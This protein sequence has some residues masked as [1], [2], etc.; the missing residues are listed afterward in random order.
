MST[1]TGVK[2]LT[3]TF[4]TFFRFPASNEK[5][6]FKQM[7]RFLRFLTH[8]A[9]LKVE[10][11]QSPCT[12]GKTIWLGKIDASDPD[13]EIL[14]LGHGIHEVMHVVHTDM[15]CVNRYGDTTIGRLLLNVLEDVR[16]DIL[17]TTHFAG[18]KAWRSRLVEVLE[19]R[20]SLSMNVE[21]RTLQPAELLGF[22]LHT[23][24]MV[25]AGFDW[26][27]KYIEKLE[28]DIEDKIDTK[29][30]KRIIQLAM[31]TFEAV[32][33]TDVTVLVDQMLKILRAENQGLQMQNQQ[34]SLFDDNPFVD[35]MGVDSTATTAANFMHAVVTAKTAHQ[36]GELVAPKDALQNDGKPCK[37]D[38]ADAYW[39]DESTNPIVVADARD[40]ARAFESVVDDVAAMSR[41]FEELLETEDF[42][43]IEHATNGNCFCDNLLD[44]TARKDPRIFIRQA[45]ER[46]VDAEICIL[47]D[48]SGSMGVHTMTQAKAAVLGMIEAL[49]KVEG[50]RVRAACFPGPVKSHVS[51]IA[52][53]EE[54][55]ETIADRITKIGAYGATP[56]EEALLWGKESFC[57]TEDARDRL[58]LVITD[59]RFPSSYSQRLEE[60]L[61]D[62]GVELAILS[63]DIANTDACTNCCHIEDIEELQPALLNLFSRTRFCE[64]MQPE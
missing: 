9:D 53:P 49:R 37:L 23:K 16:I 38:E 34:L 42:T 57:K 32:N 4:P 21:N 6:R 27:D 1:S 47:L 26:A 45:I 33:T 55:L 13:Y 11:S 31:K 24:L 3:G 54:S 12:N 8:E 51:V 43:G 7:A 35:G 18:Y 30:L 50:C 52:S 63:I 2:A 40:Y 22:Y 56:V 36:P 20:K 25:K 48:R 58:L 60:E 19:R 59:G 29:V 17:G 10:F 46:D 44:Y 5:L 62:N 61:A 41:Q 14:T 15:T 39:P 28:S 64:S